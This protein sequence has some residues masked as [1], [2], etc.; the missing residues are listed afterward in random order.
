MSHTRQLAFRDIRASHCANLTELV[1]A[2]AQNLF[3]AMERLRLRSDWA[4]A[5]DPFDLG[6]PAPLWHVDLA[7]R[8][9]ADG[10]APADRKRV[11]CRIDSGFLAAILARK[12]HW[13]NAQL[14]FQ[15]AWRREPNEYDDAL[16]KAINYFHEPAPARA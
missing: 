4:L 7:A 14:S 13:N 15:L 10:P 12:S 2:A 5:I 6:A 16:Y 8:A 3:A 9:L 1:R 11:T